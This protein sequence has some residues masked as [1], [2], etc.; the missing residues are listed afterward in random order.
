MSVD[1][2]TFPFFVYK[3]AN[4]FALF[5]PGEGIDPELSPMDAMPIFLGRLLPAGLIGLI[6]AAMIAAFMSTH[7]SY[8]LCWSS[9]I[10][11][12]IVAPLRQNP[13]STASRVRLTRILIVLMG[14]YVLYWSL[15]YRGREDIWD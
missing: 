5:S 6:S 11:Q 4:L 3:T 7:D 1:I 10:T 9:V 14:G 15:F 12:D 13:M 8:L 2:K